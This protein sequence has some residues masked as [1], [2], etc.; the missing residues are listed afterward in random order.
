MTTN[1]R[2]YRMNFWRHKTNEANKG[3]FPTN[4]D[5]V[6][7][8]MDLIDFS[9]IPAESELNICDLSG[10][11]GEQLNY[12]HDYLS[13]KGLEPQSYYNEVTNE[14]YTKTLEKYGDKENFNFLNSDFFNLKVSVGNGKK[15]FTIIRNNPPYG[16]FDFKGTSVRLEDIFFMRNAELQVDYGI[17]IFEI[18]IHQLIEEKTLIRK[19]FF[20]Y[21]NVSI[22]TFPEQYFDKKQ[23]CLIGSKKRTNSNDIELAEIW[24]SRLATNNILSL[25]EVDKPVIKLDYRAITNTQPIVLFR[26]GKVS[27]E[28]L[29]KGFD[30]SFDELVN[31]TAQNVRDESD[32]GL[33]IPLIEQ[34]PGHIA[35]DIF[36][37]Q[38]DGL[39]GNILVKGGVKKVI[40]LHVEKEKDT[41][42][43]TEVE[44]IH[45][46]IELTS[47]NGQSFV[48]EHKDSLEEVDKSA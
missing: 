31:E 20:R 47:A 46:F 5:I 43:T 36:S 39:I 2:E 8:E 16:Y 44:E 15:A 19:I 13:E 11:T 3:F 24:R 18:P 9:E 1:M 27:D 12:M 25:D 7:L 38:Y 10:G 21:E 30:F 22:F 40:R 4:L 14:R 45:P 6:K 37:G 48:K 33:K 32:L 23:V 26:D 35:L 34:L 17:Q 41:T 42:I 29:S 28:T